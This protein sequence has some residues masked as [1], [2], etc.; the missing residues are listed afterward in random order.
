MPRSRGCGRRR[1]QRELSVDGRPSTVD[2]FAVEDANMRT[3]A[4]LLLL[5]AGACAS[6]VPVGPSP[7]PMPVPAPAVP[8]PLPVLPVPAA[9]PAPRPAARLSSVSAA[10]TGDIN[11]GTMTLPDGLP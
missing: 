7:A 9:Q 8:E 3:Y 1:G 2:R 6:A 4:A 11:L 5:L 10:F